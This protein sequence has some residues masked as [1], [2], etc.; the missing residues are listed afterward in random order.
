MVI[1]SL[2]RVFV[3]NSQCPRAHAVPES[4]ESQSA[5]SRFR[6]GVKII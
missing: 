2:T 6:A 1:I 5:Y 3:Q 4:F